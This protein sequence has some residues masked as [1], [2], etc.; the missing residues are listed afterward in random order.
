M[1]LIEKLKKG[2][3]PGYIKDIASSEGIKLKELIELVIKGRVVVP[4]NDIHSPQRPIAIGERLS[5][6]VNVNLGTSPDCEDPELELKKLK[7]AQ[8]LGA[9]TVM[10]LSLGSDISGTRRLLLKHC[11]VPFGTVPVYETALYGARVKGNIG[12]LKEDDFLR[13]LEEQAKDGV[14]FFTIH[15]SITWEG[16]EKLKKANRLLDIVSRGG[17]LLLEWMVYNRKE[18]PYFQF[19]DQVLDIC[20]EFDITISLGDAFRPGAILD[21]GDEL[22]VYELEIIAELLRRAHEKEV[23]A[24]V[25]G[26]GHVPLDKI[27]EEINQIKSITDYA[28]L[29]VLGPL[30]TDI[31]AGYDHISAAIGAAIAGKAGAD[32]L[33][34][35][36]PAEHLSLP[37]I[38]DVRDGIIAF[39][40]AAQAIDVC[41][42]NNKKIAKERYMS[43][44]R[45]ERNWAKQMK[46]ALDKYK[47][48]KQRA[49][50][51]ARIEDTCSM[52]SDYC[53]LKILEEFLNKR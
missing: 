17:A 45:R 34:Y 47:M 49:K 46:Y 51:P 37:D 28:P 36:T 21:A 18:N 30:V 20:R 11:L 41:R 3:I 13:I 50:F 53:S 5:I 23:Q 35:V 33:C 39:K 14:D 19:F 27:E 1:G 26:P 38:D 10:D 29:Y 24:M 32:F 15:A 9:D 25:E 31:S 48:I 4:Y 12:N 43:L 2:I 40:I 16:I 44:A 52:C 42:G 6:K 8:E 22:Q 7:L